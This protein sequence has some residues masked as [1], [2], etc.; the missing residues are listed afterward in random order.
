MPRE[1]TGTA[2]QEVLSPAGSVLA[3]PWSN[4]H[5]LRSGQEGQSSW[6][7]P[8]KEERHQKPLLI[9]F[10]VALPDPVTCQLLGCHCTPTQ[11]QQTDPG[12]RDGESPAKENLLQITITGTTHKSAGL[13]FDVVIH[14]LVFTK[15]KHTEA[16]GLP[17]QQG[18]RKHLG[19]CISEQGYKEIHH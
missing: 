18:S 12:R 11:H 17:V 1:G 5:S 9:R 6:Q 19:V 8:G 14:G 16:V 10:P 7:S 3:E 13:L 15:Q 4:L 2:A